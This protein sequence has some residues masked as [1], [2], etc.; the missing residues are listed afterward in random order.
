MDLINS[1]IT[2][3]L[4]RRL[5]QMDLFIK[6]PIEVQKDCL[7]TLIY[8]AKDTQWGRQY[9]YRSVTDFTSFKNRVP[10]QD[11]NSLK[12]SIQKMLAGEKNVL[13]ASE[14][15]WFAKSSGTTE[16]RSKLIPVSVE[17]LQDCHYKGGKDMLALYCSQKEDTRVFTGKTVMMGG[18]SQ[19]VEERK[20]A[21]LGDLSAILIDNLPFW[22]DRYRAPEKEIVLMANWE[23]KI[24]RMARGVVHENVTSLSGVPSWTLVL[25]QKILELSGKSNLKEVWPNF[26]LFMHGGVKFDPY[27]KQFRDLVPGLN[28]YETYNASEGYFG[29]QYELGVNDFL[30]MLDYGIFY[31]FIP[32]KNFHE[33]EPETVGLEGVELGVNYALVITTNA[34]LWRYVLGDTIAFTSKSPFRFKITGRTKHFINA[35][36]EELIIDNTDSAI[37]SACTATGATLR[38]Y[39]VAPSYFT[40]TSAGFHEWIIEFEQC[41][42][43]TELFARA[44]DHSLKGLNSDYDAKRQYDL[45]LGPPK[46]IKAKPG[47]FYDWMKAKNKIGGQHKVPRLSNDRRYVEELIPYI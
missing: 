35:F 34:G 25:F 9:D 37:Q 2:W 21:Q 16:D 15:K 33:E 10:L 46:I 19:I 29:I 18:S 36:G 6:Y 14:I 3:R 27:F 7:K 42:D 47:A 11:Y 1:I 24:E 39:T 17:S 44:L 28:F 45:V 8:K 43:N 12:G 38:E 5:H 20:G 32:M 23:E 22:V 13:W 31:E 40:S 30:L 26:E 41:P 4:K